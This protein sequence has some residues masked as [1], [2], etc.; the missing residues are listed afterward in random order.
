MVWRSTIPDEDIEKRG[1]P[2][3]FVFDEACVMVNSFIVSEV[4]ERENIV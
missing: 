3:L 2:L 1:D 4:V